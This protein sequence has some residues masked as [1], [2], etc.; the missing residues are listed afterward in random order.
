MCKQKKPSYS[1][2]MFSCLPAGRQVESFS[3]LSQ[4]L[5]SYVPISKLMKPTKLIKPMKPLKLMKPVKPRLIYYNWLFI[6]N[7]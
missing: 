5:S 3:G 1:V 6:N 4:P 2:Q 7:L